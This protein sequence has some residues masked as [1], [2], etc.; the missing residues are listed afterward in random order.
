MRLG[1]VLTTAA[2]LGHPP[3]F[4]NGFHT[5]A[6]EDLRLLADLGLGEV[7][8]GVDWARLQPE[9]GRLDDDRAAGLAMWATLWEGPVPGW[10]ADEGGFADDRAAGRWWP[11]WVETAADAFGDRVDGWFPMDDPVSRLADVTAVA[12]D[13]AR[14]SRAL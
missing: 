11:R 13:R 8:V 10:F 9:P 1:A 4:G 6:A 7:R 5:R 2:T 12:G 14:H 3:A